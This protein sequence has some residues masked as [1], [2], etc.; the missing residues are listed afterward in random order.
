METNEKTT[1]NAN[2]AIAMVII[3][4]VAMI[5]ILLAS[6]CAPGKMVAD[7]YLVTAEKGR[8][9]K[10]ERFESAAAVDSFILDKT[11]IDINT[12]T[13]MHDDLPFFDIRNGKWYVYVEKQGVYQRRPEGKERWRVY[14]EEMESS[15][16]N[17]DSYRD[18]G[19]K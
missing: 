11:G 1:K 19:L 16:F 15:K 6:S 12:Q 4:F 9:M 3:L 2:R 17:P 18:K 10:W 8:Q 7:G 5:V 13:L 14:D